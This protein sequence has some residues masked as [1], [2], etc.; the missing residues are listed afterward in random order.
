MPLWVLCN[1]SSVVINMHAPASSTKD[2]A[3]WVMAKAR[4]RRPVLLVMR[5]LPLARFMPFEALGDG[6]RGTKAKITAAITASAT[7]TQSRLQAP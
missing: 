1:A 4:W 2:A 7:P 5:T 3:I 6:R